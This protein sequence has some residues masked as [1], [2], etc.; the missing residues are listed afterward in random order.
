MRGAHT[1]WTALLATA[2]LILRALGGGH[3]PDPSQSSCGRKILG[4]AEPPS[5]RKLTWAVDSISVRV[6]NLL[7]SIRRAVVAS[8]YFPQAVADAD[9]VKVEP[10]WIV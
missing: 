7:R 9:G 6:L 8:R 2:D 3:G 10:G 4:N 5:G 1:L